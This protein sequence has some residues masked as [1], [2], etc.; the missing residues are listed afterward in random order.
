MPFTL[1]HLVVASPISKLSRNHLPIAALAIGSITPDALR[2]F[3]WAFA[4]S[5]HQWSSIF[6]LHSLVGIFFCLLWYGIYRPTLYRWFSIQD[7]LNL[8]NTRQYLYFFT[9]S[10]I[11]LI[12]G[13]ATHLLWDGLTHLDSRTL[14][15]FN[16]MKIKVPF[17]Q[18][19]YPIHFI[20]QILCSLL[21]LP[22]IYCYLLRY[23]RKHRVM[24]N[25]N[26]KDKL[27]F[28]FVLSIS[29]IAGV[30][31]ALLYAQ[32]ISVL[33]WNEHRYYFSGRLLNKFSQAF[34]I[35]SS[36]LC[37]FYQ[38]IFIRNKKINT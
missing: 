35:V 19:H 13:N 4:E 8:K 9:L 25:M 17:F 28:Q 11:G 30:L 3:P 24:C 6:H 2:I 37:L 18:N 15:Q 23:L 27:K 38:L 21:P 36:L 31:W 1:A 33:M 5:S 14:I 34:L 29:I 10:Y 7:E 26:N 12:I 16:W 32:H 20:L 22:F